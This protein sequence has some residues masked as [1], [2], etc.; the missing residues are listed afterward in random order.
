M[1][2]KRRAASPDNEVETPTATR[3]DMTA[4][5]LSTMDFADATPPTGH[6][7]RRLDHERDAPPWFEDDGTTSEWPTRQSL[8]LS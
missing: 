2:A 1:T 6:I 7:R 3:D 4:S 8:T 5:L